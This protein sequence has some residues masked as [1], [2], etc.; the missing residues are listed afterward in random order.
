M[1]NVE[2]IKKIRKSAE[3]ELGTNLIVDLIVENYMEGE[4]KDEIN[5]TLILLNGCLDATGSSLSD[6]DE[7]ELKDLIEKLEGLSDDEFL[8]LPCGEVRIIAEDAIEEIYHD[9]IIELV[10]ECYDL[11]SIPDFVAIDWDQTVENTKVDGY[12]HHFAAYDGEEHFCA[13]H[14][15]FR[16][17]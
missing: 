9:S 15:I 16:T 8:D 17:N 13:G 6:F 4:E 11:S 2:L 5:D 10:E 12:G 7:W 14:Y 3:N 1:A